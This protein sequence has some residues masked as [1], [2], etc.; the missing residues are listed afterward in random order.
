MADRARGRSRLGASPL[1]A[2]DTFSPI[3]REHAPRVL[4]A[5]LRR[6]GGLDSCEDAV[7]EALLAAVKSWP[8]DGV[9]DNPF[10]WLYAVGSRRVVDIARSD[11]ARRARELTHA[12]LQQTAAVEPVPEAQDDSLELLLLCCH[13]VLSPASS[14]AL[15]LRAVAGLTTGEIARAFLVPETTMARRITRAKE[16]IHAAGASFPEPEPPQRAVRLASALHV[17]YLLFNEGYAASSGER[18]IRPDLAAEAIR[19]TRMAHRAAP[20]APEAAGLL[21]LMLLAEARGA[22]RLDDGGDIVTIDQQDRSRWD[23]SLIAEGVALAEQALAS[24]PVGPY[25]LLAAISALHSEAA[26]VEET[27]WP[28]IL[29]LYELLDRVAPN[30]MAS[31]G[32][33]VALAEVRGP[34]AALAL[35]AELAKDPRLAEHHR[36]LATRAHVLTRL[37]ERSAAR[38]EW[39]RAAASAGN[40][41]ERRWLEA[42]A[43][44]LEPCDQPQRSTS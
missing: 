15:T 21:A 10:G 14:I 37:G 40:A 5:L 36:F 1:T 27:D 11:T 34:D 4:G 22:A 2:A 16:A 7:Q 31:L 18:L 24:G 32:R 23:R 13:P 41:V 12:R 38:T 33:A 30:P 8:H 19:L 17:L 25:Q 43:T 35:L 20:Q 29:A 26:T 6:Y 3:L 44:R 39:A 42:R 28:Q 9:P